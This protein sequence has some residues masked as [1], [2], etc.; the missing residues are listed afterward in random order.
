[1]EEVE[2]KIPTGARLLGETHQIHHQLLKPDSLHDRPPHE[3]VAV[4][5]RSGVQLALRDYSTENQIIN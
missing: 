4:T 5:H 1:M 2:I 3:T